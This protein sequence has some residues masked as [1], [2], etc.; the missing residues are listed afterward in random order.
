MM[1]ENDRLS[2]SYQDLDGG[3]GKEVNF[4]PHRY[5]SSELAP[6]GTMVSVETADQVSRCP[7]HDVSQNGVA[8]EWSGGPM[9]VGDRISRLTISFDSHD[10]YRGVARVSSVREV[11]GKMLVGASLLDALMNIDDV[12]QLRD[13]TRWSGA[14]PGMALE[15]HPWR[16]SGHLPFKAL[17]ADLRLLFQDAERQLGELEASLPWQ[18]V[19]GDRDLP[20]R[21]AL[22]SKVRSEV[23]D[24]MLS[25]FRAIG[26]LNEPVSPAEHQALKQFSQ[27]NLHEFFMRSPWLRR[28][29]EKP[30]GYAGDYELMNGIYGYGDYASFSGST[31][32]AKAINMLATAAPSSVAVVERKNLIKRRLSALLDTCKPS[33]RPIRILS[34]AAGP[35][36]EIFELLETRTSMP[37]PVEIVLFDQ[38]KRALAYAYGRLER[39]ISERWA[40]QVRLIYRHDT[41]KRLLRDP[42]LFDSVGEFDT[43]FSCGLFD[44]LPEQTA[45]TLTSSLFANLAPEGRLHIGNQTSL[46]SSRWAIEFHCD[47]YLIYRQH[48]DMLAFARAGAPSAD[49]FI[50]EEP[51]G[52]N[53]FVTLVRLP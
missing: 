32:L 15:R 42:H 1:N 30:L 13:V 43:I 20:A 24:D 50:E 37:H 8:F 34:L 31:L 14:A 26:G 19:H 3:F 9:E 2:S 48:A 35:A 7:L 4:R 53:P 22:I 46:S 33:G 12:L 25:V 18:L 29:K 17:V 21:D 52:I 39:L 44:Y 49:A 11:A 51:T 47:W 23:V 28:A 6:M 27:R 36:Q 41:I 40:E 45:V 10:A 16:F 38:D 5:P